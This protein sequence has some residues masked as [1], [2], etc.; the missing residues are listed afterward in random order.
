MGSTNA[1]CQPVLSIAMLQHY[2]VIPSL[3]I[4]FVLYAYE[5]YKT[6]Q[7]KVIAPFLFLLDNDKNR[8][9]VI[10][11]FASMIGDI[12]HLLMNSSTVLV[13]LPGVIGQAFCG[14]IYI[15]EIGLI[16]FPL[17]ACINSSYVV[18]AYVFGALFTLWK[19]IFVLLQSCYYSCSFNVTELVLVNVMEN[20]PSILSMLALFGI[21]VK[22]CYINLKQGVYCR[23]LLEHKLV[24][25]YQITYVKKALNVLSRDVVDF[26]SS[27]FLK[28]LYSRYS[29]PWFK[30]S[31]VFLSSIVVIMIVYYYLAVLSIYGFSKANG[32][33]LT[34][35]ES[36]INSTENIYP[37]LKKTMEGFYISFYVSF[38]VTGIV[39]GLLLLHFIYSH[40]A[41]VLT[42]YAGKKTDISKLVNYRLMVY[43][44]LFFPGYL[45]AYMTWG[46]IVFFIVFFILFFLIYGFIVLAVDFPSVQEVAENL[47]RYLASYLLM[48]LIIYLL[49]LLLAYKVF[50][51][52]PLSTIAI[53]VRNLKIYH[54]AM[55][56][57]FFFNIVIGAVSC[58][59][60]SFKAFLVSI[61]FLGRI[62]HTAMISKFFQKFDSGF[63]A[64][65]GF[66]HV[67]ASYKNP[68]MRYFCQILL[69]ESC[70]SYSTILEDGYCLFTD[71]R[72][73]VRRQHIVNSV[74]F[75]RWF[76]AYT[77]INNPSLVKER[78][79]IVKP[80]LP[81]IVC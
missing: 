10:L 5:Y 78:F 74:A 27:N 60:R 33:L 3:L 30:F 63:L 40:R 14:T 54:I 50:T 42:L 69:N 31:T 35:L 16:N 66:L 25:D 32:I 26:Y 65:I 55:Y 52:K 61:L 20:L 58:L 11:A 2:T 77:L 62:D 36:N 15:I 9:M 24:N 13:F 18:M 22:N 19:L 6:R 34:S 48:P 57:F 73:I 59:S 68:I 23:P 12:V 76:L 79:K 28:R 67:Q 81:T 56:F 47:L 49:Q 38:A 71:S 45:V 64:Y 29:K 7:V 37:T 8:F 75:N 53:Y 44:N 39:Y 80:R 51:V 4:I 46:M 17:F 1:T 72:C 43:Y 70:K 41:N 21:F